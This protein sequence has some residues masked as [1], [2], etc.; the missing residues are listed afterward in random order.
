[1]AKYWLIAMRNLLQARRRTALLSSALALV[2]M[3]LVLL[4]SLSQGMS[5]TIFGS[6]TLLSSGH[7]NVAGFFKARTTSWA[8]VVTEAARV[9]KTVQDNAP[10]LDH[11][12]DRSRGW[13][14]LV[15]E[16][17]SLQAGLV[18]IDVGQ[19]SRLMAHLQVIPAADANKLAK[20]PRPPAGDLH[21]MGEP[22]AM[23]LFA[24]QAERLGV[25]VGDNVTITVETAGG[26]TNTATANVVAVVKDIGFLSNFSVF[27][28]RHL[29]RQLYQQSR[30]VTGNVMVYLRDPRDAVATMG[31]LRDALQKEGFAL[32]DHQAQPFFMKFETVA[33]E[34]WTGQKL[35]LT[36]WDDELGAL[37]WSISALDSVSF[38]LIS[39]LVIMIVVGITNSMW[40][41]VRERTQEIGTLRSM[42]M[43]RSRVWLMFM[44]EAALLGFGATTVGACAG[45]GVAMLVNLA[46]IPISKEA[47]RLILMSDTL[48]LSVRPSQI[49]LAVG[50]FTCVT[51]FGCALASQAGS[52]F[53]ASDGDSSFGLSLGAQEIL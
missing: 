51:G 29:L 9:R 3:L 8:P 14:K 15:S 48:H 17:R 10:G 11:I 19:E 34:D 21:R 49:L 23:I 46:A 30:D 41:S 7:V 42:G 53:A 28:N 37:K 24:G 44:T 6:A 13:G 12:I 27:M 38:F 45:A 50:S 47:I 52:G 33:S 40:I 4:L 16:T 32:M 26:Q 2:S 1:M 20:G 43:A 36:T 31:H 18:G 25:N 39:V 22:D 5:D 35:D